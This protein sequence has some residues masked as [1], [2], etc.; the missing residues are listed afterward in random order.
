LP[1]GRNPLGHFLLEY[2]MINPG[3]VLYNNYRK[4]VLGSVPWDDLP[5]STKNTWEDLADQL[6]NEG[7]EVMV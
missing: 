4:L 1:W 2:A 7:W 6:M 3:M 5:R